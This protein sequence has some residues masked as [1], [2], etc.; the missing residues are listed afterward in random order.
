MLQASN[1]DKLQKDTSEYV[2]NIVIKIGMDD[3]VKYNMPI[4]NQMKNLYYGAV[5]L[6]LILNLII[7]ILFLLSI[8]L[9]YSLLVLTLE[10]NSAELGV[11][12]LIGS[13]K[14]GI[15]LLVII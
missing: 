5:F 2:K 10:T 7:F 12:R 3:H 8:V 1:Y 15:I 13:T 9:I 14:L 6:G 4:V 11:L